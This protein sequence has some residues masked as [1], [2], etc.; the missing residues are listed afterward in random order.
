M[1]TIQIGSDTQDLCGFSE[2]WLAQHVDRRRKEGQPVCVTVRIQTSGV[3]VTL[4]TGDCPRG[5]GGGRPPN[6]REREIFEQWNAKGLNST[7]FN[8]G[9]LMSFLKQASHSVCG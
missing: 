9:N 3:S 7:D 8:L 1:S 4:A 6:D 5:G 2:S